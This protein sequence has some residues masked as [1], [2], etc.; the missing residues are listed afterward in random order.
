MSQEVCAAVPHRQFVFTIPKR[1]RLYFRF[2][3]RLLGELCRAALIKKVYEADPLACPKCG[4]VM[5]ILSFIERRQ[6]EVYSYQLENSPDEAV[7]IFLYF[8]VDTINF[9][10][11][12]N[13]EMETTLPLRLA[14]SPF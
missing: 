8:T 4:A 3:R 10:M 7:N 2:D 5:N 11:Q 13:I 6:T 9:A 14:T 1:L 12:S